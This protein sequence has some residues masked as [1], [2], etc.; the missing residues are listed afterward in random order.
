MEETTNT[1]ACRRCGYD[2]CTKSNLIRHLKRI[3]SC[4]ATHEDIAVET[5]LKELTHK[6][7]NEKT[8]DCEKCGRRFNSRSNKS[9]H[10][11]ICTGDNKPP[12][13][14]PKKEVQANTSSEQSTFDVSSHIVPVCISDIIS[15]TTN[16]SSQD[17]VMTILK[18][19]ESRLT[20]VESTLVNAPQNN[21]II[22]NNT[23]TNNTVNINLNNF[24]SEDVSYLTNEFLA[25]C[26][27]NPKK[28][29]TSLIENIHYNKDYP[30]NHNIRCKSLKQNVFEKY[31]D[32]QWRACD[33][34]NTLDELI[35]RG[36]RILNTY[37]V[38]HVMN[39]PSICDDEMKQRAFERF[40][41]LGD[42]SCN[43]YYAVKRELRILVKDRTMYV[44]Q[45]PEEET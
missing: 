20:R 10:K 16:L 24:G 26:I 43:D 33:A 7:Y 19:I 21:V 1:H 32:S 36:Y 15:V 22:Q 45:S 38:E 35:R 44:L 37:Y 9:R 6:E 3:N 11:K 29:M 39:D 4:H 27:M 28:G 13:I 12:P 18:N 14:P 40:R 31:V 17:E 2:T 23:I 41:F 30:A 5:Y 42:T 34:S 8:Y 25:Y